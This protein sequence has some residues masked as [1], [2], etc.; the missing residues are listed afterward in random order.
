ME[1]H[2]PTSS[3][4][5]GASPSRSPHVVGVS[6]GVHPLGVPQGSGSGVPRLAVL[7]DFDDTACLDNVGELLLKR[8]CPDGWEEM[9]QAF[10]EGRLT[11][12]E[13]QEAAFRRMRATREE[14][15]GYVAEHARLR[16]GFAELVNFCET[17]GHRLAIV[18]NG[19][20]FYVQAVLGQHG[21]GRVPV[22]AVGTRFSPEGIQY[23]Y[24]YATSE[25]FQWG[26]CKCRILEGFRQ[27]GRRII[28][29]GD[30]RSDHCAAQRAD[31]VFAR[32]SLLR[33]CQDQGVPHQAFE[34]FQDVLQVLLRGS[35]DGV[36]CE[37][38]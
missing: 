12:R 17:N 8:F 27:D 14:M 21:L 24:P 34:E 15:Q 6:K 30:G 26:N 13:Y 1:R 29:I 38:G 19:L 23:L 32:S 20:D 5:R 36:E 28:Y 18:T 22:F 33:L 16:P 4:R 2:H 3:V 10:R 37:R 35:W 9:R 31:F 7:V 11:L 25:C